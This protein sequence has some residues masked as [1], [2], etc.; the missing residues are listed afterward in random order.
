M[1]RLQRRMLGAARIGSALLILST[2]AMAT[3]RFL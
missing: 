3:A 2:L 1:T